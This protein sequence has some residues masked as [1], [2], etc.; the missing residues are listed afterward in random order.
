MTVSKSLT[1]RILAFSTSDQTEVFVA[2]KERNLTRF[3][4][5]EIHQNVQEL[6][7]VVR[8]RVV[9]D[10][11]VGVAATNQLSENS[12]AAMVARAEMLARHARPNEHFPTLLGPQ[13]Y[14]EIPSSF[15]ERTHRTT[16][17]QRAEM[18]RIMCRLSVDAGLNA[19]G[20]LET[21]TGRMTVANSFGLFAQQ[22]ATKTDASLVVMGEDSSGYSSYAASAVAGLDS[23]ALARVAIDKA[24]RGSH[25]T[26]IEPGEYTVFLEEDAVADLLEHVADAGFGGQ[27]F[28]DGTSFMAGKLG[29]RLLGE[30]VS[31]WDDP[32]SSEML[33]VCFDA[34][35][36]PKN[37][38]DFIERG[39]ARA[40]THDLETGL[41]AGSPSTGHAF[42]APNP[43]G[44]SPSHL[45]MAPGSVPKSDLLKGIERGIWVTRFHY[46]NL[47]EFHTATITGMTRDGT[48]LIEHGAL[49]RPLKNLRFTTGAL[50]ALRHVRGISSETKLCTGT[51][52]PA[53]IVDGFRFSGVTRF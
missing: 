5:S 22:H 36:S 48:Y 7:T 26:F 52:A 43:H 4:N 6:D 40:V 34:E 1:D 11:R 46:T 38:L 16:P 44:P 30:N 31:I 3:A 23:E 17:Q 35:G 33:P 49:T 2:E 12:L 32:L 45:R 53:L 51:R 18:A 25:P 28:L 21:S 19:F 37:R 39:V 41:L 10:G 27:A 47:A 14:P 20:A 15:D 13:R 50:E 29:N 24:L 8:V 9:K 42:P